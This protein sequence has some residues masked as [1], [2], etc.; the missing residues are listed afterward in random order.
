MTILRATWRNIFILMRSDQSWIG[1]HHDYFGHVSLFL[2]VLVYLIQLKSLLLQLIFLGFIFECKQLIKVCNE[3]FQLE[4]LFSAIPLN[5]WYN[6]VEIGRSH[7]GTYAICSGFF[8]L[9]N[10]NIHRDSKWK[11]SRLTNVQP[12][13]AY[14]RNF[15]ELFQKW[16]CTWPHLGTSY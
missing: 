8:L 12:H 2:N 7:I 16:F 5:N 11:V 9:S 15:G 13:F 4:V 1:S 10:L 3:I 6:L 14:T